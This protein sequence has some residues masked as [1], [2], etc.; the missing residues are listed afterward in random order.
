VTLGKIK[1]TVDRLR[2]VYAGWTT[3]RSETS[4]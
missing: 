3:G 4:M 1:G 2:G